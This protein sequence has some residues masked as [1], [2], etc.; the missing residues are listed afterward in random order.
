MNEALKLEKLQNWHPSVSGYNLQK[1][2]CPSKM[3][4]ICQICI[5][6]LHHCPHRTSKIHD[7]L[8]K[9]CLISEY[10]DEYPVNQC[11]PASSCKPKAVYQ[12]SPLEMKSLSTNRSDYVLHKVLLHKPRAPDQ[13]VASEEHMEK[14]SVY[15]KDYYLHP[16][17][18]A[19]SCKPL[20]CKKDHRTK[21]DLHSTYQDD[22]E[23]WN[24]TKRESM[25]PDSF[26]H[27]PEEKFDNL[28]TF[29]DDF[30]SKPIGMAQSCKP[31][32]FRS[33]SIPPFDDIT[34]Y[35]M[36][37]VPHHLEKTPLPKKEMYKPNEETFD[38]LT[39]NKKDYKGV[40]G[41]AAKSRKPCHS[42]SKKDIPFGNLTE[43]QDEYK[44]WPQPPPPQK[45]TTTYKKPTGKLDFSST[46][47]NDYIPHI[48]QPQI[49]CKPVRQYQKCPKPFNSISIMRENYKPWQCK[50]VSPIKP[51]LY[52]HLPIKPF[53]MS[54]TVRHDYK[55]H[56]ITPT[57]SFKPVSKSVLP[58]L[59]IATQ[60]TYGTGYTVKPIQIC[61]A[62]YND[63]PGYSYLKTNDSGHKFYI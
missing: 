13:Y 38:C 18:P 41:S 21:M 54:T 2:G 55:P 28:S 23:Q 51:Q 19:V 62:K 53:D 1:A 50:K 10:T 61:P 35:R 43:I 17:R 9:P 3:K 45:K 32:Q 57:M 4:C 15:K 48:L 20:H 16:I 33:G 31:A 34:N 22:Y 6:G 60:T 63:P 5:C 30:K 25:K 26:Y 11:K 39:T 36:W 8:H 44:Q 56:D 14:D 59:P 29:Q 42:L 37:Y 47:H 12:K 24:C 40:Q 7:K 27:S 52:L 49:S 46:N 58:P